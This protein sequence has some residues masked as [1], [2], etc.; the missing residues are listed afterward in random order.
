[1]SLYVLK[2]A[3]APYIKGLLDEKRSMG[4]R[5][6]AEE[7]ILGKFD[8]YW[9]ETNGDAET[10]TME[11]LS[12]WVKQRPTE[13]KSTQAI[14]IS[15]VRQLAIYMNGIGKPSYIP[16]DRIRYFKPVVHVLTMPEINDFFRIV[17]QFVPQKQSPLVTRMAEGY[18]V[19]FRLIL[20]TGLRRNEAVG[21]RI[22]D[23]NWD[24]GSI[25]IYNAKGHKDRAVFLS[26]DFALILKRY[27]AENR[28]LM[29]TEWVF[30][31][32]DPSRHFSGGALAIR[33]RA[34]WNETRFAASSARPPT[35]HSLR[36]T[37]VVLRMNAWMA[38]GVDLSAMLPY[39]SRALGHKSTNETFYYYHY[40][41][42]AFR[43]IQEKD[44]LASFVFPEVRIR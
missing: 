44:S 32:A 2:S 7:Y 3:I 1:M 42:E 8:E 12:G 22:S 37:Y 6:D 10:I 20:T 43:I 28:S 19:I 34:F 5:Y 35:L 18:R 16:T 27:I 9:T 25:T 17:D 29:D 36:H 39:L 30:P 31:A 15:A 13:G 14:R 21:L 33:F 11:S 41:S 23:I 38:Q 4:F 40:V 24:N 26:E